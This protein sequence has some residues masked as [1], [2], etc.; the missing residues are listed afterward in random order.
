MSIFSR[1]KSPAGSISRARASQAVTA[2]IEANPGMRRAKVDAAQIYYHPG[3]LSDAECDALIRMI[4]ANRRP[5]TLLSQSDDPN[6]RTSESCDMDRWSP[7]V[8]PIDERMAALLGLPPENG[9]TMQGQ[10][11]APGQQFRAHYDWFNEQQDYWPAMKASGGQ[12]TWT[13][14]IYLNDVEEGGATWFPQAGV[15]VAPKRGLLLAWNNMKPDGSPNTGTLHEGTPV[16]KGV[17]YIITKWF[18]EHAWINMPIKT[19]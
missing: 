14:M 13:A 15:R 10:R 17:K 11:Y 6:F 3:F 1:S 16:V 5:S 19:Y 12:R 18:R 4:D 7:D 9:E 8:R 2:R